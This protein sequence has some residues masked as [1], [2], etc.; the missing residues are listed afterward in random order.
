MTDW[1]GDNVVRVTTSGQLTGRFS[2]RGTGG[3]SPWGIA[4]GPDGNLWFTEHGSDRIARITPSGQITEFSAGVPPKAMPTEVT[5]GADGALWFAQAGSFWSDGPSL[6]IGRITMS[7]AVSQIP[8]RLLVEDVAAGADGKVY[9][10]GT[11]SYGERAI[12]ALARISPAGG[13]TEIPIGPCSY[14][15]EIAAGPDGNVWFVD[16][17]I[18]GACPPFHLGFWKRARVSRSGIARIGVQCDGGDITVPCRD[19]SFRMTAKVRSAARGNARGKRG[20]RHR[21]VTVG[22]AR[23]SIGGGPPQQIFGRVRIARIK[24]TRAGRKLL[25][26]SHRRSLRVQARMTYRGARKLRDVTLIGPSARR[27]LCAGHLSPDPVRPPPSRRAA[28][29]SR[30]VASCKV[31]D[32]L[33]AL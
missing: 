2:I 17:N 10:T 13:V 5:V 23:L 8:T 25:A 18:S 14:P 33:G 9:A 15:R 27:H 7:G 12:G 16:E 21:T 6:A 30:A 24:L 11:R 4:A 22:S 31:V 1:G 32:S 3:K 28:R 19:V 20:S 29:S 26:V